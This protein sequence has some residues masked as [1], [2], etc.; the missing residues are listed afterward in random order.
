MN[1]PKT[2]SCLP[3]TSEINMSFV[4]NSYASNL[5]KCTE[6]LTENE[7]RVNAMTHRLEQIQ[8]MSYRQIIP[9]IASSTDY[10][11]VEIHPDTDSVPVIKQKISKAVEKCQYI[12]PDTTD[13]E[14]MLIQAQIFDKCLVAQNCSTSF[15]KCLDVPQHDMSRCVQGNTSL[16]KCLEKLNKYS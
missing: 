6:C 9:E 13:Q 14:Q 2:S 8:S 1:E 16:L 5:H 15:K 12:L 11:R 4:N 10:S 7:E 3:S